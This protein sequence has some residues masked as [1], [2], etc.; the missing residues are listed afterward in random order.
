MIFDKRG[1]FPLMSNQCKL[2]KPSLFVKCLRVASQPSSG[3]TPNLWF[4][5]CDLPAAVLPFQISPSFLPPS[6]PPSFFPSV[7][8]ILYSSLGA[9]G[10]K[11]KRRRSPSRYRSLIK[12]DCDHRKEESPSQSTRVGQGPH[13]LPLSSFPKISPQLI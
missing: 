13:S 11:M 5:L 1:F 12:H 10:D 7:F 4:S 9:L 3:S 2:K 6:L 8:C